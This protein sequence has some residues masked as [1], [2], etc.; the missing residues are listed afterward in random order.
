[1]GI[2][3]TDAEAPKLPEFKQSQ[4]LFMGCGNSGGKRFEIAQNARAIL[5]VATRQFTDHERM[6][7]DLGFAKELAK[8]RITFTEVGDPNRSVNKDHRFAPV[9]RLGTARNPGSVPPS[10]PNRLAASR[11]INASNP[12]RTSAVFF[13]IPVS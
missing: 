7:H 6:R 4:N 3:P 5:Q 9:R 10:A 8:L 11:A 2:N 12:A 13:R 1:V